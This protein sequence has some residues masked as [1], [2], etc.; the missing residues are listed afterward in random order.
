MY[1]IWNVEA[2]HFSKQDKCVENSVVIG[3]FHWIDLSPPL[4]E[5]VPR[6]GCGV[7]GAVR[8]AGVT[9]RSASVERT[10]L[11]EAEGG[12]LELPSWDG[13]AALGWGRSCP[14]SAPARSSSIDA[15]RHHGKGRRWSRGGDQN[16]VFSRNSGR[17]F[18][19]LSR[20]MVTR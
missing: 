4:L 12:L 18:K 6:R 3:L 9:P 14:A 10:A 7:L 17:C 20:G 11:A 13:S 16:G 15:W 2:R 19:C 5:A 8:C 1:L